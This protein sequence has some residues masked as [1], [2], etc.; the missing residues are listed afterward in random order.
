MTLVNFLTP[1]ETEE[2]RPGIFIQKHKDNYRIVKPLA[3]NGKFRTREQLKTV[4]NLRTAFTIALI[5][6]IAYSYVQQTSYCNEI[7]SNPCG[8]LYN[9]TDYCYN[10]GSYYEGFKF[11]EDTSIVQDSF[12]E[13]FK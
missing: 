5:V 4:F 3:W 9:L 11:E 13:I 10:Q 1:K 8:I 12:E 7:Q 2:I 6:F